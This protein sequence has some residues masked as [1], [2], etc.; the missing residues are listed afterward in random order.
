MK[1]SIISGIL[2]FCLAAVLFTILWFK[3]IKRSLSNSGIDIYSTIDK[4]R[5]VGELV[6]FKIVTKEIYQ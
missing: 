6:V 2:G 1:W 3:K 5:S 4:F